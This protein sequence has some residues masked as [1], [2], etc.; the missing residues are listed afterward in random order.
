V[1]DAT[2]RILFEAVLDDKGVLTGFKQIKEQMD[3][4]KG[5]ATTTAPEVQ[6]LSGAMGALGISM[7]TL[8]GTTGFLAVVRGMKDITSAFAEA[9]VSAVRLGAVVRA[10]GGAAGYNTEQLL[11]MAAGW[12]RLT[13]ISD[14]AVQSAETVLLTFKNIGH[15]IFPQAL[16]ASADLAAVM[17]TDL[18]SAARS[19]GMAL[20][21][22]EQGML[23]LRRAGVML[24]ESVKNTIKDL[25]EQGRTL[26]AQN[27]LLAEIQKRVGGAAEALGGTFTAS[28]NKVRVA[29]SDIKEEMGGF[30]AASKE[31]KG[32]LEDLATVLGMV[33]TKLKEIRDLPGASSAN[34]AAISLVS[35][36]LGA[37]PFGPALAQ[38]QQ[39]QLI[40]RGI[41][42]TTAP[43]GIAPGLVSSHDVPAVAGGTLNA[44]AAWKAIEEA[45]KDAIKAQDKFLEGENKVTEASFEIMKS[46]G[47]LMTE[48]L[49]D[50]FS[51]RFAAGGDFRLKTDR[52][53]SDFAQYA[54]KKIGLV[55]GTAAG[56]EFSDAMWEAARANATAGRFADVADYFG[57]DRAA[58]KAGKEF[59]LNFGNAFR[60]GF[61]TIFQ[62]EGM[63][64]AWKAI[65]QG[66]AGMFAQSMGNMLTAL[67]EGKN[68]SEVGQAGGLWTPGKEGE[69][70]TFNWEGAAGMFGGGL[71][72]Y[73]MARQNRMLATAGSAIAG[74]GAGAALGAQTG[75]VVGWV[76]ALIGAVVGGLLGYFSSGGPK[77]YGFNIDMGRRVG[78]APF[79]EMGGGT[80]L[81]QEREMGRQ[82]QTRYEEIT[83]SF[84][85]LLDKM[86]VSFDKLPLILDKWV[87]KSADLNATFQAILRGELP[88]A[89][90]Q[91]YLPLLQTGMTGLGVSGGRATYELGKL[92]TGDFDKALAALQA[93]I[94]AVLRLQDLHEDLAKS[95][96]E[97]ETEL[98]ASVHDAW[99][100]A[101]DKSLEEIARLSKGLDSLT[102]EE[103]VARANQIADLAE[104]QY[105]ANL[106]YLQQ[107]Y[108][109][110]QQISDSFKETFLGFE[111]QRA[112]TGGPES[113]GA[114]YQRQLASLAEQMK[115]AGSPEMLQ[116]ITQQM[117]KYGQALWQLN[118]PG[119]MAPWGEAGPGSQE[120]VEQFLKDQ[121]A[122]ADALLEGWRAEVKAQ[123][124]TLLAALG[125]ITD[126]LT[127]EL[128]L[129]EG[130]KNSL[131]DEAVIRQRLKD[132]LDQE[133]DAH[134]ALTNA[135][136]AAADA[137][138]A[139]GGGGVEPGARRAA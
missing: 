80:G 34:T 119:G 113:L 66:F 64:N 105:K 117:L 55:M 77:Q 29:F 12:Q 23:R 125:A 124:D 95:L 139:L 60:E 39:I 75:L 24:S 41:A 14:E 22:P 93:Y 31:G 62:G 43:A 46:V 100:T 65:A 11:Q 94:G 135:A 50:E 3:Q 123:N 81:I 51:A 112:K 5:S 21:D 130:I 136:L 48:T 131:G 9:E 107:L 10:T 111:E 45:I 114:F 47:T 96:D 109:A 129:R 116:Q 20:E 88:R 13:G 72:S 127:G 7:A 128:V 98:T 138:G 30:L 104:N 102:S 76:G 92:M 99:K 2:K 42:S 63:V 120:W 37:T 49:A 97:L 106:Q 132:V 69:Q 91:A 89:I 35:A 84:R 122:A 78:G 19:L 108:Q 44:E 27:I 58:T 8:A 79:V 71:A 70:G 40:L 17:G 101:A 53:F 18:G 4:V 1:A 33:A 36:L 32:T 54:G 25:W 90:A 67:F 73:G 59:S 126:A 115:T 57:G 118:L 85:D 121:Q 52:A 68:L 16:A 82:L 61:L 86:N 133:T 56:D 38:L 74:A 110:Q 103:Q 15:D 134:N 137:L 87:G 28:L 83:G 6:G 26:E